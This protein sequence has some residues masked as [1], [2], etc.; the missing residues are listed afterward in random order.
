MSPFVNLEVQNPKIEEVQVSF[1]VAF[2]D[3]IDDISF[4]RSVLNDAIVKYLTPWSYDEG[5]E[6]GF[7]GR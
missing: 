1:E 5:R 6:I 4:Y 7:G 3:E 2:H